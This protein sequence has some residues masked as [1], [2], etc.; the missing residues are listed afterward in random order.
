M[1]EYPKVLVLGSAAEAR[2]LTES[3]AR[4]AVVTMVER[5]PDALALLDGAD[6]DALFCAWE[7]ADG[8]WRAVLEQLQR[9]KQEIPVIVFCHS[10]GESEWTEVL[11]AGGFDFLVPPY[12]SSQIL[13]L[14]EQAVASGHKR[15]DLC[16]S[17]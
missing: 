14:M 7:F 8:N 15:K 5:V 11:N 2:F 13:A 9:R 16:L 12:G 3:L 17:A 4:F 10:G 1:Q 6:Y